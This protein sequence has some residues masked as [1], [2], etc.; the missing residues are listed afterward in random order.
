MMVVRRE[1]MVVNVDKAGNKGVPTFA[2]GA[3][4]CC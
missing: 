2:A 1:E 3:T 4:A